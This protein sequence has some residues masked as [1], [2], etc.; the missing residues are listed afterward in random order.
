MINIAFISLGCNKNLV[1]SEVMMGFCKEKGYNIV[2]K[3]EEANVIVINTCGFIKD[4]KEESIDTILEMVEYKEKGCK[5]IVTGCLIERYKDELLNEIPE[6]DAAIG[7]DKLESLPDVIEMITN[8]NEKAKL[9]GDKK[10]V[11]NSNM[12]RVIVTPSF[13]AY[14]KIAEGCNNK[15]SYCAIPSIRGPY[16]SRS[17]EDIIEEAKRLALLNYRELV[18]TAQ[19]TTK[20]GLDLYKKKMLPELLFRLA[21]IE[22]IQWI[23]ILYAYPEDIDFDLIKVISDSKKII[24]YFDIPIQHINN[25]ILKKMNRKTTKETIVERIKLI[26]NSFEESIIRTTLLIGFPTETDEQFEE[27][28]EFVKWAHFDR[29]GVFMYS[30]EEGT[31]AYML[32]QVDDEI[33]LKRFERVMSTQKKISLENNKNRIGKIYDVVIENKNKNN[34]YISRSMFEAPEVDGKIIAFSKKPLK[35]GDITKVKIIDAFEYDLVGEVF[36]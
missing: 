17:I 5:I 19:D 36:K 8:K 1:D 4:A 18:L 2:N 26:R 16:R 23:R 14:I 13:Y 32:P 29:M 27:L 6:I 33:K 30:P 35:S 7:I 3:C 25:Q 22:G 10:F 31:E 9:F 24:P 21:Q 11:Y 20:Y 15:C 28:L 34:F 12:P